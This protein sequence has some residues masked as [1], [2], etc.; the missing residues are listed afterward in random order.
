MLL[1]VFDSGWYNYGDIT[2]FLS[3]WV[4][5]HVCVYVCV[6]VCVYTCVGV[7]I[8]THTHSASRATLVVRNLPASAEDIRGTG[9]IPGPQDPREEEMTTCS[10]ILP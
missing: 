5:I 1:A 10:S 3:Y 4:Y 6:C 2:F 8:Y 7:C 9:S